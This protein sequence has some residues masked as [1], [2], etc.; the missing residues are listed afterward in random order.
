MGDT[1]DLAATAA[2]DILSSDDVDWFIAA[3]SALEAQG[4][5]TK[6][7]ADFLIMKMA[8][9]NPQRFM[10]LKRDIAV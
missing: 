10:Q 2:T 4:V 1:F 7:L 6:P 5:S 3:K 9:T 8:R